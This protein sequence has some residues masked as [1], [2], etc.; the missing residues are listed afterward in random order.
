MEGVLNMFN[1][2]QLT[3]DL[4]R[5]STHWGVYRDGVMVFKGTKNRCVNFI[6]TG[7]PDV[8]KP[9]PSNVPVE[10]EIQ[11]SDLEISSCKKLRENRR[12]SRRFKSL[13]DVKK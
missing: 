4:G 5:K 12:E 7:S 2:I 3:T 9:T 6:N 11:M 1:L 13:W 10:V 8:D